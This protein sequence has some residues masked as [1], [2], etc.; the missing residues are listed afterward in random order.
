MK[1]HKTPLLGLVLLFVV[2]SF[3]PRLVGAA[4]QAQ[5][6]A[7]PQQQGS[8]PAPPGNTSG[9]A[10]TASPANAP[11]TPIP[12]EEII[13]RFAQHESEFKIARDNYTY[14]QSVVIQESLPGDDEPSGEYDLD[15]EIIFTPEGHRYENVTYAPPS[16]LKMLQLT[17]QDMQDIENVQPFVLT[18]EDLP[19]YDVTYVG[20][21]HIDYLDTYVF[22]VGPKKI[23]KNQRYFQGTIWVDDQDYAVVK[24]D[25]KA[26]PDII[27]HSQE[28]LFPRFV[29]Y[30]ENIE[31]T[32]WF[33]TYTRSD[34][35]LHFSSGSIRQRMTIR[36]A[37]YKRYG[38]T[39]KITPDK[40]K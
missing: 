16:S 25:G 35:I 13:K 20:R 4:G 12:V 28:N 8:A 11:A 33:P 39:I 7:P 3:S 9:P 26:V 24:T 22:H 5:T 17:Q 10:A 27:S 18:T 30:R 21:E 23:E 34:D 6:S 14:K 15:S 32:F 40:T 37:D 1:P 36:Y 19:K 2:A 38:V 29:T 31:G